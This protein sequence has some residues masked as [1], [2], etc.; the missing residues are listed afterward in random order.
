[1][2]KQATFASWTSVTV[3]LAVFTARLV[4]YP[5]AS[6]FMAFIC[7]LRMFG[8][9]YSFVH[10]A[11]GH[12]MFRRCSVKAAFNVKCLKKDDLRMSCLTTSTSHWRSFKDSCTKIFVKNI[13]E[14]DQIALRNLGSVG[15][16][17]PGCF[18][19][20]DW[21][22]LGL[23]V[24]SVQSYKEVDGILNSRVSL[25]GIKENTLITFT[26]IQNAKIQNLHAR[27]ND[28]LF[29]ILMS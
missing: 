22:R 23:M 13:S 3:E 21:L 6:N 5:T 1:M 15:K 28:K 29:I 27:V 25:D 2:G 19:A 9:S 17:V 24:L 11:D 7:S 20:P 16:S 12:L 8:N 4:D 26:K 14:R 18:I 10:D